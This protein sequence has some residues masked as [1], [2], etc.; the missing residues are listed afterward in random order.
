MA[1][2][3]FPALAFAGTA[4]LLLFLLSCGCSSSYNISYKDGNLSVS[5]ESV[6]TGCYAGHTNCSSTC[7]DLMQDDLN[8]GQCGKMCLGWG[9]A[10]QTGNCSCKPGMT[11]CSGRCADL[12]TD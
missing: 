4:C 7:V 2:L 6:K 9:M 1:R 3:K 8:C 10:C 11:E 12:K 5:N